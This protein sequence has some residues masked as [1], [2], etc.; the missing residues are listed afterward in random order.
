MSVFGQFGY[1]PPC[2]PSLIMHPSQDDCE[3]P[4][5]TALCPGMVRFDLNPRTSAIF[6]N[7]RYRECHRLHLEDKMDKMNK[8]EN[9]EMEKSEKEEKRLQKSHRVDEAEIVRGPG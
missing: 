7:R 1:S 9:E 8:I 2:S 6:F 4:P 5:S 3:L